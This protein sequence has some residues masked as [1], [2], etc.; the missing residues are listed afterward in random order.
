MP[1]GPKVGLLGIASPEPD[2]ELARHQA[3][4]LDQVGRRLATVAAIVSGPPAR[5]AHEL[6]LALDALDHVGADGLCLVML[7]DRPPHGCVE[8]LGPRD[9]PLLLANVQPE[10]AIGD[11]WSAYDLRFNAGIGGASSLAA[12]LVQAGVHF[13]ALT[14]DWIGERFA[15]QFADWAWAASAY[16]A[17]GTGVPQELLQHAAASLPEQHWGCTFQAMDWNRDALLLDAL[18]RSVTP[19]RL[20]VVTLVELQGAELRLVVGSGELLPGAQRGA[21]PPQL[22]FS[23]DAGLEIFMDTWLELGATATCVI[24]PGERPERWRRLA[25]MLEIEY[26][27]I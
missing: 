8:T 1:S 7:G 18:P 13:T 22:L 10:R 9:I 17:L 23:P 4:F 24:V 15:A 6:A 19:G 3:A 21:E 14:G 27:E 16:R 2:A 12:R 26:E 11:D 25:E 20:T 5:S